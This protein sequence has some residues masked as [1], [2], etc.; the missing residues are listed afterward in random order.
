MPP[1][2][3]RFWSLK[4]LG[5]DDLCR[6]CPRVCGDCVVVRKGV[7]QR[8]LSTAVQPGSR[9]TR[10][11]DE[12]NANVHTRWRV[13]SRGICCA[14]RCICVY[15]VYLL[16]TAVSNLTPPLRSP[17]SILHHLHHQTSQG[18]TARAQGLQ[19]EAP[20]LPHGQRA[21]HLPDP[22]RAPRPLRRRCCCC[23]C[24]RHRKRRNG[25]RSVRSSAP[26]SSAIVDG[27]G[28]EWTQQTT[29]PRGRVTAGKARRRR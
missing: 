28:A 25:R 26:S 15:T 8:Q 7:L 11:K 17:L 27:I 21:Q 9:I 12:T 3:E 1:V 19:Q 13:G 29:V 23:C 24:R 2:V 6:C 22:A 18:S 5:P 4:L 16:L 14:A 10:A 20:S